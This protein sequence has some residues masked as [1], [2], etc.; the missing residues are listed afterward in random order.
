MTRRLERLILQRGSRARGWSAHRQSLHCTE[1]SARRPPNRSVCFFLSVCWRWRRWKTTG[2]SSAPPPALSPALPALNIGNFSFTAQ[3]HWKLT[4]QLRIC[5][6]GE[7]A[8]LEEEKQS[9]PAQKNPKAQLTDWGDQNRD[10]EQRRSVSC[11]S[12]QNP[13]SQIFVARRTRLVFSQKVYRV[14]IVMDKKLRF[15][16]KWPKNST[17]FYSFFIQLF[18]QP[19]A[20]PV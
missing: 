17:Y 10:M 15:H 4:A 1:S 16:I 9:A 2:L 20:I 8:V 19:F 6:T 7:C 18:P 5:T 12:V 13:N 3:P 11:Q 14:L